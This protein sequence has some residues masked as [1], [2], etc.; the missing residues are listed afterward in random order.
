MP[1]DR[2]KPLTTIS[3]TSSALSDRLTSSA[4]SSSSS[5]S[6]S[7]SRIKFYM[8]TSTTDIFLHQTESQ[9]STEL[10][11]GDGVTEL[12]SK[13]PSSTEIWSTLLRP[14]YLDITSS[15]NHYG[16][17][18]RGSIEPESAGSFTSSDKTD[19]YSSTD[20][21][22]TDVSSGSI[23]TAKTTTIDSNPDAESTSSHPS[24]PNNSDTK[25][26]DTNGL[27]F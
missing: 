8:E 3:P 25:E 21:M 20:I 11:I 5:S 24:T 23:F 7:M 26:R 13:V 17:T 2:P 16:I 4:S 10:S 6:V 15:P 12:S 14:T 18:P 19:Q 27:L 9:T 1:P 22:T